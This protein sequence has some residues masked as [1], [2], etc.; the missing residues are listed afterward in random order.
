MQNAHDPFSAPSEALANPMLFYVRPEGNPSEP[1]GL[2]SWLVSTAR[3]HSV[4]PRLLVRHFLRNSEAHRDTWS[5]STFFDRDCVT[6]NGLG[7]YAEAAI[8]LFQH[9]TPVPLE[10]LT[11]LSLKHLF[12]HNGEGTLGRTRK[13]CPGC[14]CEQ[15]RSHS[16]PYSKLAWS[17]EHYRVCPNH[18]HALVDRCPA[19]ASQQPFLSVYPSLIHCNTCGMSLIEE[20]SNETTAEH[21][22]FTPFEIWC[23]KTLN[24]LIE[25]RVELQAEGSLLIFRQNVSGVVSKLSPG[26]KKRLCEAV[27]LQAYALNG[28]L[29]KDERPSM[30]VL[31]RFCYGVSVEMAAMFLPGAIELVSTLGANL[32]QE[33]DRSARPMLGFRQREDMRKLLEV[34]I[35]DPTDSR[36]LIKVAMQLG[37]GRS[38][39]KY[40]FRPE[41]RRLVLKN[42]RSE[43]S[44]LGER[45]EKEHELLR[46]IVQSLRA[47]EVYPGRRK[48]DFQLRK[49]GLS[50]MRPDLFQAYERLRATDESSGKQRGLNS[51]T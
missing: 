30:S 2:L 23:A 13:W 31:L 46:C 43:V 44:R 39:M 12:P 9:K 36:P 35:E 48:V 37:I 1:E 3:A 33:T 4:N 51:H 34:I 16:R 27:G 5:G 15:V 25:R 8:E 7:H 18:R 26:N 42:R 24:N 41:C 50:L 14:L 10:A 21:K 17:L 45:Y 47:Q 38:A 19:C 22:E 49:N 40:W 20:L 32:P 11:L 6:M 28:W 29:N